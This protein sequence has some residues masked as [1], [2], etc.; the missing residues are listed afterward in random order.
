MVLKKPKSVE[1][2]VYFTNRIID[3]GRAMA[4]VFRKECPKCKKGIMG[5][6][7][8]KNGKIDK[9]ADH[10]V[11]YSCGYQESNEQVENSLL[12]NVEYKCPHCGNEGETT[13][14]YRRKMFEGVPSYVFECQKCH[15]GN[16]SVKLPDSRNYLPTLCKSNQMRS[17]RTY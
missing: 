2:C 16:I 6:P 4:W 1:E 10:Y 13:S 9:K 5:K 17:C 12:I 3:S 11:C 7:Q 8:K 15:I 14:E